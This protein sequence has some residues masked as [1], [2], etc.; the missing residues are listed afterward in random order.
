MN[1]HGEEQLETFDELAASYSKHLERPFRF[2]TVFH[3]IK[4]AAGVTS[5]HQ[6]DI[7]TMRSAISLTEYFKNESRRIIATIAFDTK[8]TDQ[9]KLIALIQKRGGIVTPRDLQRSNKSR[10]PTADVAKK[11]LDDLVSA[12][13]GVWEQPAPTAKGGRSSKQFRLT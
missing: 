9:Q 3:F 13:L 10:H 4:Q 8:K 5:D 12:G 1:S 2:A 11:A 6:I 7:E